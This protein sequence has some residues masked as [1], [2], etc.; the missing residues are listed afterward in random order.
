M[1]EREH[2]YSQTFILFELLKC[3][4]YRE[5]AIIPPN[6]KTG[7]KTDKRIPTRF[8]SVWRLD[9]LK[10]L[11]DRYNVWNE[12]YNLYMGLAQYSYMP[13]FSLSWQQRKIDREN[14]AKTSSNFLNKY[15]WGLDIDMKDYGKKTLHRETTKIKE[16]FDNYHLPY[17]FVSTAHGF[18]FRIPYDYFK[19][20]QPKDLYYDESSAN[21]LWKI[22][23]AL[24]ES[25]RLKCPDLNCLPDSARI[26]ALPYSLK[27]LDG[28]NVVV[29]PLTDDQ[30]INFKIEEMTPTN[31]L[32]TV[33]IMNRGLLQREG[34]AENVKKFIKDYTG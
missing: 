23:V 12:T 15:D 18:Q 34:T 8:N 21:I 31:I 27:I 28:T 14:W 32:K 29:T 4:K 33:K 2:W 30:F 24:K 19:P 25:E 22:M 3:L 20:L 13:Y 5:L 26:F 11:F 16:I 1:N 17:I 6:K 9:F 7:D 10:K